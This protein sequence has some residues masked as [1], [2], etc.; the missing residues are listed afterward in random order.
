MSTYSQVPGV[1][2][3]TVKRGDDFTTIVDFDIPLTGYTTTSFV[4]SLVTG[5]EVTPIQTSISNGS[6]GQVTVS[7]A[8]TETAGLAPG[9]YGWSLRWVSPAGVTRNAIGGVLEVIK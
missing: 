1:L 2:N 6:L 8:D 4:T 9:S 3:F 7:M 5:N